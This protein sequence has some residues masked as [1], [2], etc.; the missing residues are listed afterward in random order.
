[1][2]LVP[3]DAAAHQSDEARR[4]QV[5]DAPPSEPSALSPAH[6]S[7]APDAP[8]AEES[9]GEYDVLVMPEDGESPTQASA[10]ASGAVSRGSGWQAARALWRRPI[11]YLRNPSNAR[12][13]ALLTISIVA[14]L[15]SLADFGLITGKLHVPTPGFQIEGTS[16]LADRATYGFEYD[17]NGWQARGAAT[18]AV[19][20]NTHAFAGQGALEVQLVGLTQKANGFVFLTAPSDVKP[21]STIVAHVYAPTGTPP[22]VVTLYALDGAWAWSSGPYPSLNPG[23]WVA[24]TYTVPRT[25]PAPIREMGVMLV[26]DASGT[27]FSG[28]IFVD[29]VNVQN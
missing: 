8:D 5:L 3:D 29:S 27:P 7:D 21:G 28:V 2:R 1:M 12:Y 10:P 13:S 9:F 17:T 6:Q 23:S 18:S 22:L 24:V 14:L 16:T 26:G 19:W 15:V 25:L 11:A 20:N 4:A